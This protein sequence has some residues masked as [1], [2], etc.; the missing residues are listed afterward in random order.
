VPAAT[1][2][3]AGAA[4]AALSTVGSAVIYGMER[5]RFF[6]VSISI[7]AAAMIVMGFSV[8]P[9]FGLMGAAFARLATQVFLVA[10]FIWYMHRRLACPTPLKDLGLIFVSAFLCA[11]V[12]FGLVQLIRSPYSLIAAIP[13]AAITYFVFIRALHALPKGDIEKLERAFSGLPAPIS[14]PAI[15]FLRFLA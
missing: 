11:I 5:N 7:A 9:W 3:V 2:L 8:V 4:V 14:R 10:L 12:A 6:L 1:V 15:M 13:A